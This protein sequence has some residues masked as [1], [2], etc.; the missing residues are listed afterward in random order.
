MQ[1]NMPLLTQI[2]HYVAWTNILRA[3]SFGYKKSSASRLS[4][5]LNFLSK[6]LSCRFSLGITST[7]LIQ[8]AGKFLIRDTLSSQRP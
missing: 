3:M 5:P 2:E 8:L 6:P 7:E 1:V 4:W